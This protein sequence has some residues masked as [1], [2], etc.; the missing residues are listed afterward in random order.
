[1]AENTNSLL[2]KSSSCSSDSSK[3]K[4]HD[5]PQDSGLLPTIAVSLWLGWNGFLLWIV[6]YAIFLA[7][8]YQRMV[9]VG[10]FTLS[11]VLPA[12]FP[13]ALGYRIGDWMMVQAEKY[14]G[15]KTVIEDEDDLIRHSKQKKAII[16]A[17]NPHDILP[18]AVFAFNPTLRRLPGKIGEDG[19]CL[20]TSAI[21]SIPLLRHVYSWVGGIPVDKMTFLGRLHRGESFAF[22]PGG[23]HEVLMLNPEKPLDVVLYLQK[24]KGF[25]KLAL[26]TGSP[27]VPVF[28]F[29]LDGSY[30]YWFPRG[31]FMEKIS[32]SLKMVPL[33]FWG[34]WFIPFGIPNPKKIHVVIG[35]AIDVPKEGDSVTQESVDKYHSKFL[36]ELEALFER[37]KHEAGYADRHLRII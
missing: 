6:I 21:F 9:I 16:F 17:F 25:I 33:V 7:D 11:L 2:K 8:N 36:E 19:C 34:R 30:G 18:Y 23:V 15:L 20:M 26:Q 29:N 12:N 22:T 32:R 35:P 1:M 4:I 31:S 27:V 28:G 10:L 5:T 14:F 37:H 3:W 13:G 24:R